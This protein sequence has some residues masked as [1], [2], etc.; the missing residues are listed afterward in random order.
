MLSEKEHA[1]LKT[2]P[3][4]SM[5]SPKNQVRL[6]LLIISVHCYLLVINVCV[7]ACVGVCCVCVCACVRACASVLC[8]CV[9]VCVCVHACVCVCVHHRRI[10]LRQL[11][12]D[13]YSTAQLQS[14]TLVTRA[15]LSCASFT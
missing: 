13:S 15:C 7:C 3:Y 10:S 12:S 14:N 2:K 5:F 9:C 6:F 8:V 1:I 4:W 11:N